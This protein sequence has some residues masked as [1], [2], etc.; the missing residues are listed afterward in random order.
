MPTQIFILPAFCIVELNTM[1]S[2]CGQVM[3]LTGQ[4]LFV[5]GLFEIIS[6]KRYIKYFELSWVITLSQGKMCW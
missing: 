1:T 6:V 2:F 3:G 5:F 4:I